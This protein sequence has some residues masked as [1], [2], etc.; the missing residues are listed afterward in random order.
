MRG[1]KMGWFE[2]LF[3]NSAG[4]SQR[5]AQHAE[6]LVRL[7]DPGPGQR[8]LDVGCGNGATPVHLA[9]TF[10]LEATGVDVDPEQIE[11]ATRRADGLARARFLVVD[12]TTLQI[13]RAHV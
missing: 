3:V 6:R 8:L 2:K 13:G 4:H 5:V 7:A 10:R 11:A 1:M 12:T 9:R